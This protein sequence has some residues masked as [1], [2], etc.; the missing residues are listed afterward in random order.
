MTVSRDFTRSYWK[1]NV[2]TDF[3]TVDIGVFGDVSD[4]SMG[5]TET[6]LYNHAHGWCKYSLFSF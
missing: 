1:Q 5:T 3:Y 2:D 6:K 4:I